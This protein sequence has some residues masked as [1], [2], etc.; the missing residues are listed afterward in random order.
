[1]TNERRNKM[2]ITDKLELP[3]RQ[4]LIGCPAQRLERFEAVQPNG[5]RL[6][7][8]RC[9]DCGG[10]QHFRKPQQEDDKAIR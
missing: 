4:H 6:V 10:Q 9:I 2:S 1:M 5:Q 7:V 8:V 3:E